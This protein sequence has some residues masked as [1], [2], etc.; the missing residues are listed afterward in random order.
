MNSKPP[1]HGGTKLPQISSASSK[2][3]P[4]SRSSKA[5][6]QTDRKVT[7]GKAGKSLPPQKDDFSIQITGSHIDA[8]HKNEH[9]EDEVEEFFENLVLKPLPDYSWNPE[10]RELAMTI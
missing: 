2:N 6:V 10:M 1:Q 4:E 8:K 7:L 5:E 3:L 9:K